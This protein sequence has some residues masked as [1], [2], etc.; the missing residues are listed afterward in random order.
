MKL[1]ARLEKLEAD[2]NAEGISQLWVA[3]E[4]TPG[5][6]RQGDGRVLSE[7][8]VEALPGSGP[9]LHGLIISLPEVAP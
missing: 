9:G 5:R 8:E 3:Y 6:Y 1:S 7:A 2:S 4:V